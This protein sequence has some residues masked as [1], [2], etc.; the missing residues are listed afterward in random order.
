MNNKVLYVFGVPFTL[1]IEVGN[2]Y[3][4]S[5][6]VE[7]KKI[8]LS[9]K[10]IG[11]DLDESI[12]KF[13]ESVYYERVWPIIKEWKFK[14]KNANFNSFKI[15][16]NQKEAIK[17][18]F[19][20]VDNNQIKTSSI[21]PNCKSNLVIRINSKSGKKFLG[22]SKYNCNYTESLQ[23][24]RSNDKDGIFLYINPQKL[25]THSIE[26]I[27]CIIIRNLVLTYTEYKSIN[28]YTEI[29]KIYPNY[30]KIMKFDTLDKNFKIALD[31]II[32]ETNNNG[33]IDYKQLKL[34]ILKE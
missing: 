15:K 31:Q 13:Y 23:Y 33:D 10:N 16:K 1:E 19:K 28:Y 14:I 32:Q 25:L 24:N 26:E 22:C 3:D 6:D 30:F 34:D 17:L 9:L 12:F 5:Y 18:K 7:T 2:K 20:E 8:K 21:C 11:N 4:N 27:D 29:L